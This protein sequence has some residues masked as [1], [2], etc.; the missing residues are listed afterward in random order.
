MNAAISPPG[1]S[2]VPNAKVP[3]PSVAPTRDAATTPTRTFGE[4]LGAAKVT[5]SHSGTSEHRPS[6][7]T[8]PA[9]GRKTG[10]LRTGLRAQKGGEVRSL[11][12]P[13]VAPVL[14]VESRVPIAPKV[15]VSSS[16]PEVESLVNNGGSASAVRRGDSQTGSSARPDSTTATP[17]VKGSKP[18]VIESEVA[19][20]ATAREAVSCERATTTARGESRVGRPASINPTDAGAAS[21]RP[22]APLRVRAPLSPLPTSHPARSVVDSRRTTQAPPAVSSPHPTASRVVD[23]FGESAR[24]DSVPP[25][26]IGRDA[27][28]TDSA[29]P[30]LTWAAAPDQTRAVATVVPSAGSSLH[31]RVAPAGSL[32]V[33]RF[34]DDVSRMAS[35]DGDYR[36]SLSIH[37]ESLGPVR[38][39]VSLVG[40]DLH[41]NLSPES[42]QAHEILRHELETLRAELGRGGL[43]V[44]VTL[45][46][47][48]S[49]RGQHERRD[50]R[51]SDFI[52]DANGEFVANQTEPG[53]GQIHV[54]L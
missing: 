9:K 51:G 41:V 48:G 12:A 16:A 34:V 1:R 24:R 38:A 4:V 10:R 30:T 46:D 27:I 23:R 6:D 21:T 22:D 49:H 31:A 26:S 2:S 11:V 35:A 53:E 44:H 17:E 29:A 39:T 14:P 15:S 43:N 19:R 28:R 50:P 33:R 37:P 3:S 25:R 13:V 32:D 36:V 40:N 18:V 8:S 42:R 47:H 7:A 5:T 54:I 45:H 20:Q 52:D